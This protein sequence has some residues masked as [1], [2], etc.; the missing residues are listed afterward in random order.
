MGEARRDGETAGG[1]M[2]GRG[3]DKE[4]ADGGIVGAGAGCGAG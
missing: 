2:I 4:A 3:S 1:A